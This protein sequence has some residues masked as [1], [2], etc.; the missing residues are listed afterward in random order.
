MMK[1]LLDFMV[2][3]LI[4]YNA[5]TSVPKTNNVKPITMLALNLTILPI[6]LGIGI[7]FSIFSEIV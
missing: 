1:A 7:S 2:T 5:R 3:F 4:K 6:Q